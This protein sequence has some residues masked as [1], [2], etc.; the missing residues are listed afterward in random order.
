MKKEKLEVDYSEGTMKNRCG[1][2]R[3]FLKAEQGCELVKG[4]ILARMWCRLWA[5]TGR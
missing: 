1:N 2:C 5:K 3:H 4:H